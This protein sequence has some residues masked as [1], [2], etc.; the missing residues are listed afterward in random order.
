MKKITRSITHSLTEAASRLLG[1]GKVKSPPVSIGAFLPPFSFLQDGWVTAATGEQSFIEENSWDKYQQTYLTTQDATESRRAAWATAESAW[2]TMHLSQARTKNIIIQFEVHAL[3]QAG[4]HHRQRIRVTVNNAELENWTIDTPHSTPKLLIIPQRLLSATGMAK[5]TFHCPDAIVNGMAVCTLPP[6]LRLGMEL[7]GLTVFDGK[8]S[9]LESLREQYEKAC[10]YRDELLEREGL[11]LQD[12][13]EL[14]DM[15][16]STLLNL[17]EAG[18]ECPDLQQKLETFLRTA[19]VCH[20]K[21]KGI[22]F[23]DVYFK[24]KSRKLIEGVIPYALRTWRNNNKAF[25]EA[26]ADTCNYLFTHYNQDNSESD[27]VIEKFL[28]EYQLPTAKIKELKEKNERLNNLELLLGRT[29]LESFP[30]HLE[31][32]M[33]SFCNLRCIMCSRSMLK[34][35][36]TKQ[37]NAQILEICRILPYVKKVTIAGVGE[38]CYS[39]KLSILSKVLKTFDCTTVMFTNGTMLHNQLDAAARFAVVSISFDGPSQEIIG[40]QRRRSSFSRIVKNVKALRNKAPKLQIAFS[41][42]VT[43]IN[44]DEL[45]NIVRIAGELGV[46]AVKFSPVGNVPLLEV[47]QSD[48]PLFEKSFAEAQQLAEKTGVILNNIVHPGA[49]SSNYDTPRDKSKLIKYFKNLEVP[50]DVTGDIETIT[51]KIQQHPFNYFPPAVV[52]PGNAGNAIL[53]PPCRSDVQLPESTPLLFDFNIDA[54][55]QRIKSRIKELAE[56]IKQN[57]MDSFKLP[58][59]FAVWKYAYS[60]S[61]GKNRLCPNRNVAVGNYRDGSLRETINSPV[62]QRYRKSMFNLDTVTP[63]CRECNDH[64]RRWLIDS[65]RVT[66]VEHGIDFDALEEIT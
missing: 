22:A 46:N 7:H 40:A 54:E 42:V 45:P 30:P 35:Y 36:F 37:N 1:K 51:Q 9:Y 21:D 4:N 8:H 63:M 33:T 16:K 19:T 29:E 2:L 57:S 25:K 62:L 56:E 34:F 11:E 18:I 49:F 60:K 17:R 38:P 59:C 48:M 43:R 64:H 24:N 31:I 50:E 39:N 14:E 65:L 5:I 32:E 47:K 3:R 52:F 44:L 66:C 20:V 27:A 6:G 28:R 10:R 15:V 58:Y 12:R 55:L 61:N 41:V 13:G 53:S 26:V 23:D